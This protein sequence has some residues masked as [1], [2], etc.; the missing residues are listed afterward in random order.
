[1]HSVFLK[2][3]PKCA[4]EQPDA[5]AYAWGRALAMGTVAWES[6]ETQE[7]GKGTPLEETKT[8]QMLEFEEVPSYLTRD[9]KIKA[10]GHGQNSVFRQMAALWYEGEWLQLGV[11]AHTWEV[12]AG[13]SGIQSFF[14]LHCESEIRL[15]T[16]DPVLQKRS[17]NFTKS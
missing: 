1:M 12:E 17:D 13:R 14:G 2:K 7:K 10:N 6:L 16:W 9:F 8:P 3:T 15:A 11:V 5:P 4:S